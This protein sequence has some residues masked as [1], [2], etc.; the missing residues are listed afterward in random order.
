MDERSPST[1]TPTIGK[2]TSRQA[3]GSLVLGQVRGTGKVD[4]VEATYQLWDGPFRTEA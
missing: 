4:T 2:G 3:I 1:M